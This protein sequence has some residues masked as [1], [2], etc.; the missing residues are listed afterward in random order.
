VVGGSEER[1]PVCLAMT[2]QNPSM[3]K[4]MEE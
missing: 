3:Q 2:R 1:W 4:V